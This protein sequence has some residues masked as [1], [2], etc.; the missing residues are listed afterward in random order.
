MEHL[1]GQT[2][3]QRLARGPLPLDDALRIG[4]EIA[5]GLA[6]AHRSGLVHRDLKPANVMLT[7][8]GAKLLD[9]GLAK[10]T[11]MRS[12]GDDPT[13]QA[14]TRVGMVVG[15][16]GFMAPE[17]L[18]GRDVDQRADIWALG[19]VLYEMLT[20]RRAF[21][22]ATSAAVVAAILERDPAHQIDEDV[23]SREMKAD[24]LFEHRHE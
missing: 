12:L 8:T 22:G 14:L 2:L 16:I 20:G 24:P 6:V 21:D 9:F 13:E 18:D 3:A 23:V 19:C 10:A 11:G 7:K 15:T 1:E 4:A 17:Q 5:D